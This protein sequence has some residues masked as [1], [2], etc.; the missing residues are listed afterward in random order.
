MR[1][2]HRRFFEPDTVEVAEFSDTPPS[3]L[4][5]APRRGR[6]YQG[7]KYE[8]RAQLFLAE[9]LGPEYIPSPWL[10]FR[11]RGDSTLHWC[12]P[13]GIFFD[14]RA[15]QITIVEIKYQHC[16]DAWFQLNRLYLPVLQK[17][18]PRSMWDFATIEVVKWYDCATEVPQPPRL[19]ESVRAARPGE[20]G[21]FIWKP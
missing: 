18:F 1:P 4:G 7:I 16:A 20:F 10:R 8:R 19:R 14:V 12:Q 15:G 6:R 2:R 11:L 9:S 13:D 17:M 5:E 3:F 21:V